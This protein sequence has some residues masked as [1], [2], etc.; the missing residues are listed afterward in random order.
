MNGPVVVGTDGSHPSIVAVEAAAREARLHGTPLRVVH[1]YHPPALQPPLTEPQAARKQAEVVAADAAE[2]ARVVEPGLGITPVATSGDALT[3]LEAE[4]RSASLVV[5]G[6]RGRNAF[7]GLLLGSTGVQLAAHARSPVVVVREKW[8]PEGPVVLGVDGSPAAA[9]A[10]EFAFA[11]AAL[12][13]V[14][15][16]AVHAWTPWNVEL[17]QPEDPSM[18]YAAAPGELRAQEERLL[19]EALTGCRERYPDVVVE[20]L[21]VRGGTRES[22]VD[23]TREA[24]LVVVGSRGR[25]GFAGLLLGSVSQAVLHHA[26]CSVAVVP[27]PR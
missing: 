16:L 6:D 27:G 3:V 21:L 23:A 14:G 15:V 17:P 2:C 7:T 9:T 20:Q 8:D 18:P 19:A 10:V 26:H 1:A 5:V 11:E 13:R 22:L 12:R 24:Q 4:S 25:G